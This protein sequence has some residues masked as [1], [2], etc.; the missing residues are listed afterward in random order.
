MRNKWWADPLAF[1]ELFALNNI[2]FLAFDIAIAHAINAFDHPAEWVPVVFS[3]AASAVLVLA[4]LLGGIRPRLPG[5]EAEGPLGDRQ[6]LARRLGLAV[7]WG[8]V[9]VGIA[10]L[11][12]HLESQFFRE[13][14]LKSLVYSAPFV[15]PLSYTGV[16]LLILLNRMV[17]SRSVDWARWLVLL[18]LGGFIGNFVL[19]LTDHAQNGFFRPEEWAGVVAAA[20][21]VGFLAT[22]L[23]VSDNRPLIL[24]AAWVI[25]AQVGVALLGFYFHV[26]A[27]LDQPAEGLWARFLYGAPAFAPLLFADLALLALLSFWALIRPRHLPG[28]SHRATSSLRGATGPSSSLGDHPEKTDPA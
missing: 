10:G 7:G 21:A 5:S 3:V 20:A 8:S 12:L 14:T 15:A 11:L 1:V 23:V 19:S 13:A 2:A 26:R 22:V 18:S 28:N 16:G 25:A 24:L 27:N 9:A 4:M 17:D 6:R